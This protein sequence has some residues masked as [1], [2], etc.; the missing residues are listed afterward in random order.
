MTLDDREPGEAV[1]LSAS[2]ELLLKHLDPRICHLPMHAYTE[3]T[4]RV[5]PDTKS[6]V[7]TISNAIAGAEVLE[8]E[9]DEYK[10]E[11]MKDPNV[12]K[13]NKKD[14]SD[15]LGQGQ[16]GRIFRSTLSH[17]YEGWKEKSNE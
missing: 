5:T 15:V 8:E 11:H 9:D 10:Q 12:P 6:L 17:P 4:P 13:P 14:D 7:S 16:P 3:W 1:A 2:C